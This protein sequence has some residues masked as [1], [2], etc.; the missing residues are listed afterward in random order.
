MIDT[1]RIEIR[2]RKGYDFK[3][4]DNLKTWDNRIFA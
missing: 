4:R 2:I 1:L 3:S